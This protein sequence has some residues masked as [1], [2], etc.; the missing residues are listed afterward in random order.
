MLEHYGVGSMFPIYFALLAVSIGAA[1]L[2]NARLVMRFGMRLLS[3]WALR[4]SF[5]LCVAFLA[6]SLAIGGPP[7]L[8]FMAF[9]FAIFFF[10]G[11]NNRCFSRENGG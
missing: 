1:S 11:L 5:V 9:M 4:A 6:V 10:N 7:L 3:K 8:A 2:L